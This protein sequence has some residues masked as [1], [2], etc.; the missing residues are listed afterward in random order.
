MADV[1]WQDRAIIATRGTQTG[2]ILLCALGRSGD[3]FPRFVGNAS[4]TSDGFITCDYVDADERAHS[5]AFVGGV[6]DL[7]NNVIGLA[8]HLHLSD[9]D[10]TSLFTTI[11]RWIGCD[12]R[13]NK[14]LFQVQAA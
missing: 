8:R 14:V 2:A 12:F 1:V 3:S 9:A 7:T 10:R 5:G 4:I 11:Q 13:A 6:D